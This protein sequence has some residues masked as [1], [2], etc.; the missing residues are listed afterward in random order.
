[1][2]DY[3]LKFAREVGKRLAEIAREQQRENEYRE[4]QRSRP[5]QRALDDGRAA[6][7]NGQESLPVASNA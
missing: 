6:A 2:N 5:T 7:Q 1:M 4:Y 3:D